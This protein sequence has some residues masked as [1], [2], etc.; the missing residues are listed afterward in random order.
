VGGHGQGV[1]HA[2]VDLLGPDRDQGVADGLGDAAVGCPQST[3]DLGPGRPADGVVVGQ[4]GQDRVEGVPP[5]PGDGGGLLDE[6]TPPVRVVGIELGRPQ[7]LD[8]GRDLLVERRIERRI[9]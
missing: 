4:Q 6:V 3:E 7:A 9:G 5:V 8:R 1:D 2:V